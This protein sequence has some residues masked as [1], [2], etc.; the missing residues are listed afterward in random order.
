MTKH[1]EILDIRP[2][3]EVEVAGIKFPQ[4]NPDDFPEEHR[5]FIPSGDA[6]VV[7]SG[8]YETIIRKCA[9]AWRLAMM[10]FLWGPAGT[11]KSYVPTVLAGLMQIPLFRVQFTEASE[12]GAL[13][14]RVRLVDGESPFILAPFTMLANA[15]GMAILDEF[16]AAPPDPQ[17][18]IRSVGDSRKVWIADDNLSIDVSDEFRIVLT[19]NP[20]WDGLNF[21]L[22]PLSDA[23]RRRTIGVWCGYPDKDTE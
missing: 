15:P 6:E 22:A 14:G 16:N 12:S 11:G 4:Y 9:A 18:A 13:L 21:G 2:V 17:Q 20:D 19:G 1:I 5:M 3:G 23:D 10:P 8:Q 7:S